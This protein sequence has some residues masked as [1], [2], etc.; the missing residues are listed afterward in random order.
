MG[1]SAQPTL[2]LAGK[3]STAMP[4]RVKESVCT[5][6]LFPVGALRTPSVPSKV[7]PEILLGGLAHGLRRRPEGREGVGGHRTTVGAPEEQDVFSLRFYG[8]A[9]RQTRRSVLRRPF[10]SLVRWPTRSH[11]PNFT[12]QRSR[13]KASTPM[14]GRKL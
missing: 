8:V 2:R 14:I 4:R 10:L 3:P 5:T 13:R 9:L 11:P 1:R 12:L 7:P 6:P